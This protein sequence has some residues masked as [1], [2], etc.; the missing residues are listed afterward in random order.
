MRCLS[1]PLQICL[2]DLV[3]GDA[4]RRLP[5]THHFHMACIDEFLTRWGH[6]CPLCKFPANG[7]VADHQQRTRSQSHSRSGADSGVR[8][9]AAVTELSPLV[10]AGGGDGLPYSLSLTQPQAA[11]TTTD[12]GLAAAA[13]TAHWQTDAD[14]RAAELR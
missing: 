12:E 14:P 13:V 7:S 4:L 5:C 3:A 9:G 11:G 8:P 6:T 10:G 2:E 1:G